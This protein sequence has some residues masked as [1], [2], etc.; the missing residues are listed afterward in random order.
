M[1]FNIKI[2]EKH[3]ASA[4]DWYLRVENHPHEVSMS[5]RSLAPPYALATVQRSFVKF[6]LLFYL[7]L[8]RTVHKAYSLPVFTLHASVYMLGPPFTPSPK[9]SQLL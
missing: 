8:R 7:L 5:A 3:N 2:C 6:H 4:Q 9:G 1:V